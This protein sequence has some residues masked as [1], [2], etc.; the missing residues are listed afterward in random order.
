M[1]DSIDIQEPVANPRDAALDAIAEQVR[2]ARDIEIAENSITVPD[3]DASTVVPDPELDVAPTLIEGATDLDLAVDKPINTSDTPIIE[4]DGKQ[5]IQLTVNGETSEVEVGDA[6]V[7][8]Q[9]GE[10]SDLQ[11][12]LA[13]E[14]RQKAESE[15]AA[16]KAQRE[17]VSTQP[18]DPEARRAETKTRVNAALHNLYEDGD[19]E[20]S[21]DTLTDLL[22]E[23]VPASSAP[24][25]PEPISEADIN[26]IL[27]KREDRKSLQDAFS[28]FKTDERFTELA[29]NEDL[30]S[31]VDRQTVKVQEDEEFMANSPSYSDIFTKAGENV[32]A[33]VGKPIADLEP[34]PTP[35]TTDKVLERKR[36][37]PAAVASRTARRSV[38]EPAKPK[39]TSEIIAETAKSRGQTGYG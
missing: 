31:L 10:N 30:M 15:T 23:A 13:V 5:F 29:G 16:L 3:P 33:I 12:K 14:A 37:Q 8:L 26:T 11:T 28:G 18:D 39:T 25:V 34:E 1:P 6:V 20:G 36:S 21:T 19:V 38:P 4:R 9:K 24:A 27:D 17:A 32:L 7:R 35:V 22:M 2:Q